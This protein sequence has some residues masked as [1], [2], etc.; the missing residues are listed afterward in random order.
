MQHGITNFV[1]GALDVE[2]ETY[3]AEV[4]P[5]LGIVIPIL[6]LNSGLTTGDYGWNTP[7]FKRMAKF[8]FLPV[9]RLLAAGASHPVPPRSQP[10]P[11]GPNRG[12]TRTT[13]VAGGGGGGVAGVDVMV[14]DTDTVWMRNPMPVF[15]REAEAD[16]LTSTDVLRQAC[17]PP[18]LPNPP[19]RACV[20]DKRG[21]DSES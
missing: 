1:V 4:A 6:S 2:L 21:R 20:K 18:H 11:T 8:K 10:A 17:S 13:R 7:A 14:C 19:S 5:T 9:Q 16:I 3:L 12:A 15:A